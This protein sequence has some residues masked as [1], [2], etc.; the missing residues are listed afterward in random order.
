M[1]GRRR[2]DAPARG[3]PTIIWLAVRRFFGEQV[4]GL[5][6]RQQRG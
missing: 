4:D 2:A 6:A 5:T 1:Y 3:R